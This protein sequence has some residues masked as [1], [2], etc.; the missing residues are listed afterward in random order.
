LVRGTGT[1]DATIAACAEVARRMGKQVNVVP[2][3]LTGPF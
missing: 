3:T 2:E 1:E